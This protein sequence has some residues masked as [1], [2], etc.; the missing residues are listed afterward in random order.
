MLDSRV[1]DDLPRL[2]G[3]NQ[4]LMVSSRWSGRGAKEEKRRA[5]VASRL[6]EKGAVLPSPRGQWISARARRGATRVLGTKGWRLCKRRK[7]EKSCSNGSMTSSPLYIA[8]NSYLSRVI[9]R[10]HSHN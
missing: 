6:V 2:S 1:Q 4:T 9:M 8:E 10:Q 7:N 3:H 5:R